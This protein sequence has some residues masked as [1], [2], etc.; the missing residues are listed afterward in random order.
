MIISHPDLEPKAPQSDD[1][2]AV[3]IAI[4]L[5]RI[6]DA[7]DLIPRALAEVAEDKGTSPETRAAILRVLG[8][9]E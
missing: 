1:L 7:L 6:A 4:S 9:S 8:K 2:V 3:S 5:K